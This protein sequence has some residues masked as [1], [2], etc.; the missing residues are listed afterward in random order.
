MEHQALIEE[1]IRRVSERLAAVPAAEPAK[2]EAPEKPGLL[3]LAPGHGADCHDLLESAAV[4]A[5]YRME[6]A[7][8]KQYAVELG[9]YEAVVLYGL[10]CGALAAL[11]S[12][13]WDCDY[14]RLASQAILAGKRVYVPAEEV[15]LYRCQDTAPAPYYGM[16]LRKLRLLTDSGVVVCARSE[17]EPLLLGGEP[18]ACGAPVPAAQCPQSEACPPAARPAEVRVDKRVLTERDL[19]S[20]QEAGAACIRVTGR[21][22]ITALAADTAAGRGIT[23]IRDG[24]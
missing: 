10:S 11:A 18:Q 16:L 3:I 9:S 20:A 14:T 2:A 24:E 13:S 23:I 6:C 5:R 19:I 17:L 1:I 12:G 8:E 4:Q 22:I 7:L 15:G 21:C